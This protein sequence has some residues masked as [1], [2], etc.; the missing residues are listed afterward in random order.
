MGVVLQEYHFAPL[1]EAFCR[2]NRIKDALLTLETMRNSRVHPV[3][4]TTQ[5]ILTAIS[6]DVDALDATWAIV[7]GIHNE[8]KPV[9]IEALDLM[10]RAAVSLGDLQ[11]AVGIYKAYP[12]FNVKPT[13]ETY[14]L[15]IANCVTA[16]HRELGDRLLVEMAG[17]GVKPDMQTYENLICLCL[18]QSTYEDAFFYLEEMKANYRP[19][20][21]V[22][23]T[24][25]RTC[26]EAGDVRYKLAL[27]EM[28]ECGYVPS[29]DLQR[30]VDS[31][32]VQPQVYGES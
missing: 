2:A 13:V 1:I 15:L 9:D 8:G 5:A 21:H 6:Q 10:I 28:R 30:L 23:E 20:I 32:A 24:L 3:V 12:D 7:E 22:Y 27:E 4:G 26:F 25:V 31:G 14:N 11:R 18:T 16:S 29:Q 19:S 17:A